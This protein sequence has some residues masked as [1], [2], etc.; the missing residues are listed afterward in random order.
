M[1]VQ[2]IISMAPILGQALFLGLR[3]RRRFQERHRLE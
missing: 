3:I 2:L 1:L